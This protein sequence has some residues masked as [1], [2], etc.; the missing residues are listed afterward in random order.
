MLIKINGEDILLDV[1]SITLS[2]LVEKRNI[3][4]NGTAIAVNNRL[5]VK[6]EWDTCRLKD[7]DNLTIISAAFGG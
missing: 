1:P 4:K 3:N 6:S 7:N 5:I 2:D